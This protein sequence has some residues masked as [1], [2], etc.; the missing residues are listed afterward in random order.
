MNVRY[1]RGGLV[2]E[3]GAVEGVA[4]DGPEACVADDLPDLFFGCCVWAAG[5]EDAAGVVASEAQAYLEDLEALGFEVGLDVFDVVEVEPRDGEGLEV[6]DCRGF[7]EA[8]Y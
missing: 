8:G 2:E 3:H 5:L 1:L 7:F 4:L 6:F